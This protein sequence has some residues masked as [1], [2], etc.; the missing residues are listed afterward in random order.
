MCAIIVAAR[1]HEFGINLWRRVSTAVRPNHCMGDVT[2]AII[3]RLVS[4]LAFVS[5]AARCNESLE[6]LC[7]RHVLIAGVCSLVVSHECEVSGL[8]VIVD[9]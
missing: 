3:Q 2:L 9:C 1:I 7:I 8:A 6:I 5:C 4:Q